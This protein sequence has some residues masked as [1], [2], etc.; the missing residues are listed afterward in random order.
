VLINGKVLVAG[1]IG[2][3]GDFGTLI[4]RKSALLYNPGSNT[5]EQIASMSTE[6]MTPHSALTRRNGDEVLV[7]GDSIYAQ[8]FGMPTEQTAEALVANNHWYPTA[9]IAP[10]D[11]FLFPF[12]GCYVHCPITNNRPISIWFNANEGVSQCLEYSPGQLPLP[13][14]KPKPVIILAFAQAKALEYV[15]KIKDNE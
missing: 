13:A 14:Q 5:W 6:R 15:Q 11:A 7:A 3:N 10:E 4:I 8:F 12:D 1:G 2:L 9:M